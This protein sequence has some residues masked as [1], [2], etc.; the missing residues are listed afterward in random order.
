MND[1]NNK[2]RLINSVLLKYYQITE[3]DI[4]LILSEN[5]G[6]RE[7]EFRKFSKVQR[8]LCEKCLINHDMVLEV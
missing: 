2:Y 1:F 7:R 6:T 3:N 8:I 4:D 5:A